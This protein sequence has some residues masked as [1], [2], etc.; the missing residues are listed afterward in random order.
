MRPNILIIDDDEKITSM[1]RRGLAFEGYDVKTA[2]NG[3]DGLRAVLNSDPDVVILDVMMPQVDGFEVCR[4]LREGGSSVP[5]LMLTAKDEIEHRVKGLDLGAD[6]YLVKPFALEE[7]LARVR[8]L[9]RRKSEQGGSPDQAVTYE[10]ITLDVDSREVTRAGRR[11]ELTAKE[12]ELLHLF[13]QNPK[14][15][16]S[17]ISLWIRSGDTIT[18][19]NRMSWRYILQCCVRRRRSMAAND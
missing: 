14:R 16:L 12:F 5:V 11:L 2:S 3:A 7:L 4:R 10:D 15:V 6:D 19:G 9:L 1:L 8:A 17:A 13:M 18:A